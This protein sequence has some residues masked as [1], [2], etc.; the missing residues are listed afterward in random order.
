M[1]TEA[2]TGK[3]VVKSKAQIEAEFKKLHMYGFDQLR[4]IDGTR[5]RGGAVKKDSTDTQTS[6]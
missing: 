2:E 6:E 1:T 4:E 3:P 5:L